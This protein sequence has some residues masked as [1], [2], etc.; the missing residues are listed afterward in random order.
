MLAS[1][2]RLVAPCSRSRVRIVLHLPGVTQLDGIS[3]LQLASGASVE[4]GPAEPDEQAGCVAP[5]H[6]D[7]RAR[8]ELALARAVPF[9]DDRRA[10]SEYVDLEQLR[11]RDRQRAVEKTVRCEGSDEERGLK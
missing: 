8:R 4:A 1:G 7:P 9:H 2:R 10:L 6:R 11:R 3:Q 5:A